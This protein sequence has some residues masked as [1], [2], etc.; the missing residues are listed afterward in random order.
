MTTYK[1]F[2][3][4]FC[5]WLSC[6]TLLKSVS[7]ALKFPKCKGAFYFPSQESNR[8]NISVWHCHVTAGLKGTIE[9]R[10]S[11][12]IIWTPV[13]GEFL[14]PLLVVCSGLSQTFSDHF[15]FSKVIYM[16]ACS[17]GEVW[18]VCVCIYCFSASFPY[19]V[20]GGQCVL[21]LAQGSQQYSGPLVFQ[22]V[23]YS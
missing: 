12:W 3:F 22:N 9:V 18:L 4:F 6:V 23:E 21:F 20:L 7:S 14:L 8:D 11:Q 17:A 15:L 5:H 10:R 1:T 2:E 19:S 16:V 13:A